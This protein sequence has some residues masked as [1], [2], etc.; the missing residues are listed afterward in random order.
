IKKL[1]TIMKLRILISIT[2]IG[3]IFS[4]CKKLAED[5]SNIYKYILPPGATVSDAAPLCGSIKGVMLTG[6]TYTL[7]CDVYINKGD[8]LIIQPGV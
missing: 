7:G 4:G 8:T 5:D 2:I 3:F 1:N 6:H